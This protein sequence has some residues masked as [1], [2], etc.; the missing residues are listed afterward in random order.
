MRCG[1]ES[2]TR[3]PLFAGGLCAPMASGSRVKVLFWY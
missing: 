2:G 3:R 1:C